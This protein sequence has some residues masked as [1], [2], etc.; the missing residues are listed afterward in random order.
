[1]GGG[2]AR[3][4][5]GP[6]RYLTVYNAPRSGGQQQ[7]LRTRGVK[8]I[9]GTKISRRDLLRSAAGASCVALTGVPEKPVAA[10]NAIPSADSSGII[11]L[12]CTSGVI[13]P[14]RG[15]SFMKFSYDF[16]E[17]SVEFGGLRISFRLHTFENTYGLDRSALKVEDVP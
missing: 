7:A 3:N 9:M 10:A 12:T 16:P 4:A 14:T 13:I 11:P 2:E 15:A 6:R 17:P 8:T 1:M 5:V